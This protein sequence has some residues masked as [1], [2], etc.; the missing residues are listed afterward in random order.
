[1]SALVFIHLSDIHFQRNAGT[2]YD[3]Y[4][5]LRNELEL[6]LAQFSRENFSKIS[7]ILVTGDIAYS[8]HPDEYAFA[9]SWLEKISGLI[10]LSPAED[11][12]VIPGNH[13]IYRDTVRNSPTIQGYHANLRNTAVNVN[14]NEALV[15]YLEKDE[16]AK[17]IIFKPLQ[18]YNDFAAKY[19]CNLSSEG[20]YW[21]HKFCLSDGSTLLVRGMNSTLISDEHDSDSSHKLVVG[22][23]QLE[24][25]RQDGVEYMALCH[26]PPQWLIDQDEAEVLLTDRARLQLFGHKHQQRLVRLDDSVRLVA[27]A[28]HPEKREPNW[29]PRYNFIEVDV[30]VTGSVRNM[31]V[32]VFPRV[33]D[34]TH[35]V[36]GLDTQTYKPYDLPLS[37]W[38]PAKVAS[39]GNA[40]VANPGVSVSGNGGLRMRPGRRLTYRFLN[41]PYHARIKIVQQLG[42]VSPE[43][44]GLRDSELYIRYFTRA[45]EKGNLPALWDLID[46]NSESHEENPFSDTEGAAQ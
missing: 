25:L 31:R 17:R 34:G 16:E 2:T 30:A 42:L 21:E 7:A 38:T 19:Q 9:A 28:V 5:D 41:L 20:P 24:L 39:I 4:A 18:N 14:P 32:K 26:H 35:F 23:H 10:A 6:D 12:F 46:E 40:G 22:S 33:F 43:D 27:G 13:D 37:P 15:A 29:Q 8:G 11:V 45:V 44:E 1:M 36:N 3:P